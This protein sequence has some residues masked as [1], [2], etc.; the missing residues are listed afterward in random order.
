[1][2]GA[3][4]PI[5]LTLQ[6]KRLHIRELSTADLENIH[7]LH[8]LPET[9]QFNTLGIPD[10]IVTT[11]NLLL[12]WMASQ[13]ALPR[14]SHIFCIEHADTGNFIGLIALNFGKPAFRVAEVWYKVHVNHWGMGYT[15]EA[16]TELIK[17]GFQIGLHRIEAG[18]A[19]ENIASIKVLEKAGMKREGRKRKVLPIRGEWKDNY[20]YAILDED[21]NTKETVFKE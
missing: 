11:K 8:S 13:D 2:A 10:S 12:E 9:D 7:A 19:V 16:L 17:F 1:M 3:L 4:T 21:F 14:T 6:T 18:C 5:E 15:T 20:M